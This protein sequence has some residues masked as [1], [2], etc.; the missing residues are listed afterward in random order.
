MKVW[1]ASDSE[2][3]DSVWLLPFFIIRVALPAETPVTSAV[4]F[5]FLRLVKTRISADRE[6][7]RPM[8]RITMTEIM[9]PAIVELHS[10]L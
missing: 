4:I 9:I 6:P 8:N 7:E 1:S 2:V 5:W 10:M 3:I